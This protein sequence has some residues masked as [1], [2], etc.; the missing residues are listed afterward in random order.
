MKQEVIERAIEL[1]NQSDYTTEDVARALGVSCSNM[2]R[3]L[4]LAGYDRMAAK[5]AYYKRR[6]AE[7]REG[8]PEITPRQVAELMGIGVGTAR[9]HWGGSLVKISELRALVG[10]YLADMSE[11]NLQALRDAI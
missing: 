2:K 7:L 4:R 1:L 9:E 8:N 10:A 11:A 3:K 5:R 6:I